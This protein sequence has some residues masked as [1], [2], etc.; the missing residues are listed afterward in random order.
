MPSGCAALVAAEEGHFE[1]MVLRLAAHDGARDVHVVPRRFFT[2][3]KKLTNA[4]CHT[5]LLEICY[6]TLDESGMNL[7]AV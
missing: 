4:R 7:P 5:M 6:A 1:S 2:T 3:Y